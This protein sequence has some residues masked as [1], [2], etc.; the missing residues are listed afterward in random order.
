[1][2]CHMLATGANRPMPR[3][4]KEA[5]SALFCRY[6]EASQSCHCVTK[7]GYSLLFSCCAQQQL[8]LQVPALSWSTG[9]TLTALSVTNK[10]Q[11]K[12]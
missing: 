12:P 7:L 11:G 1:M 2:L 8:M 10:S 5:N 9:Q 6:K 3:M 4:K